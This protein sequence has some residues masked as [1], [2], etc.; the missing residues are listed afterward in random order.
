MAEESL[1]TKSQALQ[2][3][4]AVPVHLQLPIARSHVSPQSVKTEPQVANV[5]IDPINHSEEM[6]SLPSEGR[7]LPVL[8]ATNA[9]SITDSTHVQ[10]TQQHHAPESKTDAY[11]QSKEDASVTNAF[12]TDEIERL[13]RDNPQVVEEGIDS[14][15]N[16]IGESQILLDLNDAFLEYK[17]TNKKF[18]HV[19]V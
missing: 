5:R 2:L 3:V 10:L 1:S 19:I 16:L 14:T 7:Y 15:V 11:F 6:V 13:F 8:Q 4:D 9:P 18:K 17:R 12:V